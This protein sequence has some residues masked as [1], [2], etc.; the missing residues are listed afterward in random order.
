MV[1]EWNLLNCQLELFLLA[2]LK[3]RDFSGLWL[4]KQ[5]R[6]IPSGVM[7]NSSRHGTWPSRNVVDFPMKNMVDL[8]KQLCNSHYQRVNQPLN[9]PLN[10]HF[11]MVFPSVPYGF[12]KW[13]VAPKEYDPHRPSAEGVALCR[14]SG[15]DTSG[16]VIRRCE[17]DKNI[18]GAQT[19][20]ESLRRL[21]E[22]IGKCRFNGIYSW[23][24]IAKLV[25]I[26]PISRTGLW[27]QEV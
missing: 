24:M 6:N 14:E 15:T 21:L 3:S 22:T 2:S 1:D 17:A 27:Y 4:P 25:N 9:Q 19:E 16:H 26:T 12:L 7:T 23:F 8:S 20:T 11:P 18:C 10:H 5:A 13:V